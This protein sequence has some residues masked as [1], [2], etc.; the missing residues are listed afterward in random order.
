VRQIATT[1][2]AL[3]RQW[4]LHAVAQACD[5]FGRDANWGLLAFYPRDKRNVVA[6]GSVFLLHILFVWIIIWSLHAARPVSVP[7]DLEIVLGQPFSTPKPRPIEIEPPIVSV[8]APPDIV[9]DNSTTNT[10]PMAA[11]SAIVLPP[12]PD[13]THLNPP[14]TVSSAS[15]AGV[16]AVVMKIHVLPTGE[17]DDTQIVRSSGDVAIDSSAA[18]FVEANWR[19]RPAMLG[20]TPVEYWTTVTVPIASS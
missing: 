15:I 3:R 14:F 8:V 2:F 9:I 7:R 17:I 13:P 4:I 11:S 5:I 18:K 12:R 6:I 16:S 1:L 10:A 19:F 20:T